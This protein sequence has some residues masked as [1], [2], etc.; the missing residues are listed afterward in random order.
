MADCGRLVGC[1][2][3]FRGAS[4]QFILAFSHMLGPFSVLES[5]LWGIYH[6]IC[7]GLGRG[8]K[9]LVVFFDFLEGTQMLRSRPRSDGHSLVSAISVGADFFVI[10]EYLCLISMFY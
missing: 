9:K 7:M 10:S 4:N 5:E 1:G 2:G 6:G 8:L 3:I